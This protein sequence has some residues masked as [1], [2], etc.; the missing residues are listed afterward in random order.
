MY[1]SPLL[2]LHLHD[3]FFILH[4]DMSKTTTRKL[5]IKQIDIL[6]TAYLFRY[7]TTDNLAKHRNI[8]HNSAYSALTILHTNGYLSKKYNKNY[9]LRNKSARYSLTPQAITYLR[10]RQL[11]LDLDSD[12]LTSRLRDKARSSE[13]IDYQVAVHAAY[14]ELRDALGKQA[15]IRT[16]TQLAGSDDVLRPVPALYVREPKTHYFVELPGNQQLFLV[17]KRIRKYIE[18]YESNDWQWDTYPNV[19]IMRRSKA[20]RKNLTA[21]IQE[22]MDDSYLDERDFT[23][24]V[25]PDVVTARSEML[26]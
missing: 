20:D 10:Q 18:H 11:E 23:I 22:K 4:I 12:V 5:N 2:I 17:K 1:N 7:L 19:R 9:R 26:A 21:Y 13:F 25:V 6:K 24:D 15:A 16:A 3:T 8:T 14:L